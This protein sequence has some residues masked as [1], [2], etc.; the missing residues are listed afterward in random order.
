MFLDFENTSNISALLFLFIRSSFK[1]I[2]LHTK[3]KVTITTI[4]INE[5]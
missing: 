5:L 1:K 2:K 3:I 4:E